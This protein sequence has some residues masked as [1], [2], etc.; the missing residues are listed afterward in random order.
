MSNKLKEI[1]LEEVDALSES[2]RKQLQ[3]NIGKL[4]LLYFLRGAGFV[5]AVFVPYLNG[6][7]ISLS[8][9]LIL[10][11]IFGAA[12]CILEIPSGYYSDV[13]GR[14]NAL[15]IGS[16]GLTLGFAIYSISSGFLGFLIGELVLAIAISFISG[17]DTAMTWDTLAELG[18]EYE[19]RRV[20]SSQSFHMNLS[21]GIAGC[22][23]SWILQHV[24]RLPVLLETAC[25]A[26]TIP[27]ALSLVEPARVKLSNKR[28]V[29]RGI[30]DIVSETTTLQPLVR[31]TILLSALVAVSTLAAF[32]LTQSWQLEAG[33]PIAAFGIAYAVLRMA[34]AVSSLLSN[35][36]V[37]TLGYYRMVG[38]C[39]A[40]VAVGYL[41][42]AGFQVIWAIP[43]LI[44]FS[45]VRGLGIV[46]FSEKLN[47]LLPSDRRSTILSLESLICRLMFVPLAPILGHLADELALKW[48]LL[49][50]AGLFPVTAGFLVFLSWKIE[51]D[52]AKDTVL[53]G[54]TAEV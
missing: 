43:V 31:Q 14:K 21:A 50:C 54:Q 4:K 48:A 19:F 42:T 7:G 24:W 16:I 23:G 38:L 25:Y 3:S 9:V 15:V 13:Y 51:T 34:V 5:V 17:A 41:V 40:L 6:F 44:C 45:I 22:L 30:F 52:S 11:A 36:I 28:G 46:V 39:I 1:T 37:E 35:R 18:Q 33:L 32:W 47:D 20:K 12:L 8:E 29:F 26:L 53:A 10:Q 27:L 49:L 2:R